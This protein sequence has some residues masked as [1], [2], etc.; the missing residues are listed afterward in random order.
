MQQE[1]AEPGTGAARMRT[2]ERRALPRW[3][4]GLLLAG[5]C[6]LALSL[7]R[8]WLFVGTHRFYLENQGVASGPAPNARQRFEVRDGRVEPEIRATDGQRLSFPVE[9]TSPSRL[10]LRAVSSGPA[11]IEI[12]LVE[13]GSR[14]VV[15]RNALAGS[16]AIAEPV[17]RTT[18]AIELV[19]QGEVRWVDP[20]VVDEPYPAPSVL[21]VLGFLGVAA[22]WAAPWRSTISLPVGGWRRTLLLGGLTAFVSVFLC[23]ATLEAGLRAVGERLPSWIAVERRNLGEVRADPRWQ[24]SATY[25][26]RLAPHVQTMCQWQHGDIV[27]MGFLAPDLV[28]HPI[29]RFPLTTDADGF[30]NATAEPSALDL[31]ALG[32]SFTD[33]LTLPAELTWPARLGSIL[34]A[35]VRNY[36]TAGFGPGQELR[37]LKEFVLPQ[38]P[39]VVVVGFFAGNDLQDAERFETFEKSGG[40]FPSSGLGWKFKEVIARFDQLYVMS[41]YQG[42]SNFVRDRDRG[43][44]DPDGVHGPVDYSGDDPAAPAAA[45]PGFDRG[46]FTIPTAGHTLRFAFLPP[47]LN[48]LSFSREELQTSPGWEATRRSYREMQRL[49]RAQGSRL[50]VVFIP[51]KAQVYLPLVESAFSAPALA[52]ALAVSLRDVAHPPGV[53]VVMRNRLALNGLMRDFC[54]EEGIAFLDLTDDLQARL[55]AG[56]NVYFPDDSHWN[57]AG[58]ETAATA[59]AAWLRRS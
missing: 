24:D 30:R 28:R 42:A 4:W 44:V 58:H 32:D 5:E 13:G 36:G 45:R 22:L 9:L 11:T 18:Q 10:H 47:Y 39:R 35:S 41:L 48:S 37:A 52:Q 17:P 6:L 14:R 59:V 27:R 12:A 7:C 19:N 38:K 33:A 49:T 40:A 53:E 3:F 34:Q 20:R 43:L 15:Y 51:S 26:P 21:W 56:T 25:G 1:S 54:A 46:L 55:R 2:G 16:T 50:V 29:Y 8:Q 31:A 23:F 57:G